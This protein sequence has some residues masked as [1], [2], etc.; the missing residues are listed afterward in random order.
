M[1]D[2]PP[3]DDA[4]LEQ[5]TAPRVSLFQE[6]ACQGGEAVLRTAAADLSVGGMFLDLP[7]ARFRPGDQVTLRF[8]LGPNEPSMVVE[9]EV[10]YVQEGIG[11]GVRF[12]DLS[13][14]DAERIHAFVERARAR[15]VPKGEF[16]LRKSARVAVTVPVRLRGAHPS[17]QDIDE[18]TSIITLSKHGACVLTSHPVDIGMKLYLETPN[19]REFKSSIVWVGDWMSR[20]EGQVGLQCR[21]LAQSLGFQFP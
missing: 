12:L 9:A 10:N 8:A 11:M 3:A 16:H 21:G 18:R 5:R 15:K 4:N 1:D 17:G 19:G 6:V 20:S 7:L 14:A 2:A 13:E